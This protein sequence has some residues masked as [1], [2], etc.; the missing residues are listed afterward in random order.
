VLRLKLNFSSSN[1]ISQFILSTHV[2]LHGANWAVRHIDF[3]LFCEFFFLG[4]CDLFW[5]LFNIDLILSFNHCLEMLSLIV[6][7]VEENIIEISN[8][9]SSSTWFSA[10]LEIIKH[11]SLF[12]IVFNSDL[13][14][15]KGL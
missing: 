12:L 4:R 1:L 10:G 2:L 9:W 8:D 15:R 14:S 11:E 5:V 3:F 7:D 6:S 13:W